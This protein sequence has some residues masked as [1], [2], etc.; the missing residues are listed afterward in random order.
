MPELLPG[1][2]V[3]NYDKIMGMEIALEQ[4]RFWLRYPR[5]AVQEGEAGQAGHQ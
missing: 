3:V 2:S 5:S 4:V 1:K